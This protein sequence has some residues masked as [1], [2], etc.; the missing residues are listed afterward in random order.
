[1]E[2]LVLNNKLVAKKLSAFQMASLTISDCSLPVIYI[3]AG[4]TPH[5]RIYGV[6]RR[7]L[8]NYIASVGAYYA[9]EGKQ[10]SLDGI[11]FQRA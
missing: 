6:Y 11:K 2:Q 7:N 5:C 8:Q 9:N 4:N 3:A 10:T 1:M